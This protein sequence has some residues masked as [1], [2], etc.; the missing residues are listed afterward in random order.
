MWKILLVEDEPFVRRKLLKLVDWEAY[1]F[2]VAGEASDGEEALQLMHQ[3]RPDL[4][5]AD[6]LMPRMDGLELLRQTR[7]AGLDSRFVML[8]CMG[9]FEYARKALELG[10][11]GYVL[12]LSLSIPELQEMLLKIGE[13]L[14]ASRRQRHALLGQAFDRYYPLVWEAVKSG[15]ETAPPAPP[16]SYRRLLMISCIGTA[17]PLLEAVLEACPPD[18]WMEEVWTGSFT[19]DGCTTCFFWSDGSLRLPG[20]LAVGLPVPAVACGGPVPPG[21]IH[22]EWTRLYRQLNDLWYEIKGEAPADGSGAESASTSAAGPEAAGEPKL[23]PIWVMEKEIVLAFAQRRSAD[24]QR[25]ACAMWETL[26]ASRLPFSRVMEKAERLVRTFAEISNPPPSGAAHRLRE[27]ATHRELLACFLGVAD[28]MQVRM[29]AAEGITTNHPEINRVLEYIHS[30]FA[31]NITLRAAARY[32]AMEEH[33]LSGLFRLKT[34]ETLIN[35]LQHVRVKKARR[36]LRETDLTVNEIGRSVGFP[37]DNYF[38]KT[39]KKW[40]G[41]TPGAYRRDERMGG[42]G[43]PAFGEASLDSERT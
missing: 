8:T 22:A 11:S 23:P 38:I 35:Y 12:K 33:Y 20:K 9:E 26:R 5:I 43:T 2:S 32:V 39:F 7:H 27:A 28:E 37:N 40:S 42:D 16:A 34:G 6:I 14:S 1:G 3:L 19:A 13:E 4:V 30:R 31:E 24:M 10:A 17:R 41:Q 36:L 15:Q 25:T 18:T 29:A 21:L